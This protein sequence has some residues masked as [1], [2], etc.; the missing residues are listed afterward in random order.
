MPTAAQLAANIA[1]AQHSTG[2]RTGEGKSISSKNATKAGLFTREDFIRP[3]EEQFHAELD[4]SLRESLAP[5]GPLE[6][7]L[8]DEIRRAA[9]R[10]RRCAQV[11]AEFSSAL[12]SEGVTPE[13]HVPDPMQNEPQA[14]V[15]H[16]VDRARA[17]SHRLL[18]RAT[19]ELRKLQTER[20]FRG[21]FFQDGVDLSSLGI[22]DVRA[23]RQATHRET[24]HD[25]RRHRLDEVNQLREIFED[26]RRDVTEISAHQ[27]ASGPVSDE[28]LAIPTRISDSQTPRNAPC[29]CKSGMKY[30]RCCGKDAP[31]VLHAA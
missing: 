13:D 25:L 2:P 4:R 20:H 11:E 24:A 26:N 19:A 21:E 15:Q 12:Y 5:L 1:N 17:Q 31:A 8:V 22:C 29:P 30:K 16:S 10:L 27:P 3:G 7:I 6:N 9:W 28:P 14:Q 18:H 23:V